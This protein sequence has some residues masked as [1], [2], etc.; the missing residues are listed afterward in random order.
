MIVSD[1]V[2]GDKYLKTKIKSYSNKITTNFHGK[3]PKEVRNPVCFL[4]AIIFFQIGQ[5]LIFSDISRE[6][7]MKNKKRGKVIHQR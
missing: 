6:M 3:V 1:P 2:Y 4:R 5:E 7:Y